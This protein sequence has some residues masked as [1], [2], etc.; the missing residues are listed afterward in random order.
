MKWLL[1][2]LGFHTY[3]ISLSETKYGYSF[4]YKCQDCGLW[5]RNRIIALKE[6]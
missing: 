6:V 5:K 3:K 2:L 4:G 1:C